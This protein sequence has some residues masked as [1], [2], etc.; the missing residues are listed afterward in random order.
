MPIGH[1]K[2]C[3]GTETQD[4]RQVEDRKLASIQ[5]CLGPDC[6]PEIG[7]YCKRSLGGQ[8]P[9]RSLTQEPTAAA[10]GT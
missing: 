6:R 9:P 10:L 5:K 3:I 7:S 8:E 1:Q 4:V 2:P